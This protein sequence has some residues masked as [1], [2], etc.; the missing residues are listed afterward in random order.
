MSLRAIAEETSLTLRT[1][2]TIIG[3]AQGTDR[4]TMKHLAR[5]DPDRARAASWKARKRTRDALP[6]QI[7]ES[8]KTG[9]ELIKAAKGLA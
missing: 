6:K 9:R 7:N 1:V 3:R 5:I 4:T 8:L 2:R